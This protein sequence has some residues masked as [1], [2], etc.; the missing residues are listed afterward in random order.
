M[1][2][3]RQD[4]SKRVA[5]HKLAYEFTELIHGLGAA[6]ECEKQHQALFK[7]NMSLEEII[8]LA[9]KAQPTTTDVVDGHPAVS[10]N[11]K[12]QS[13]DKYS[14][15]QAKLPRSAVLEKPLSHVL[16][17]AGLAASK[18]EAQKLINNKGAYIGAQSTGKGAMADSLTYSP[19][20]SSAWNWWKPYIMED[21]LLILRTGKWRVK[22][23]D[24]IP[25]ED[26]TAQ[27]LSC[28][29]FGSTA[30]LGDQ[31]KPAVDGEP[32]QKSQPA[33]R[34]IPYIASET[35]FTDGGGW[36][37]VTPLLLNKGTKTRMA[38][39]EVKMRG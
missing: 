4:E 13:L 24:I 25:D 23:I 18:T 29:G 34:Q 5:Q 19:I 6:Q 12:P 39:D 20:M 37:A 21:H 33:E 14:T 30:D 10:K 7:R 11:A 8:S 1:T 16:W 17:S 3:H 22:I 35:D 32:A 28:P 38:R 2:E 9:K 15:A 27:G 31:D 26:F 36:D